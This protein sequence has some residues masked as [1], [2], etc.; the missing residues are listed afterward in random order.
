MILEQLVLV[1][2][3]IYADSNTIELRPPSEDRPII[4]IGGLNGGG[5][6]T[7]LDAIQLGFF[8]RNAT[9]SNRGRLPY[10]DYLRLSINRSADP[11]EGA[12]IEVHFERVVEGKRVRFALVRAWRIANG[13]VQE[14]VS[15]TR[16]ELPDPLLSE[17]WEEYIESYLPSKLA[18]LFFFDGEQIKE[19]ADGDSAA[20][21]LASAVQTL[22]GLD[23]VDR[24]DEDLTTLER[25]KKQ[26][27]LSAADQTRIAELRAIVESASEVAANAHQD[28]AHHQTKTDLLRK[29]LNAL[30]SQF[31]KEGGELFLRREEL[32]AE[33][34]RLDDELVKSADGLRRLSSGVAP[35][36]LIEPLLSQVEQ[37]SE[38]ELEARHEKIISHAEQQRDKQILKD[39]KKVIPTESIALVESVLEKNRPKR[40]HGKTPNLLNPEEEF[41]EE[42]RKLTSLILPQA[43][44]DLDVNLKTANDL[45]ELVARL[46]QQLGSV[47]DADSLAKLQREMTRLEVQVRD[48]EAQQVIH[49][50]RMRQLVSDHRNKDAA[51]KK[52]LDGLVDLQSTVEHDARILQRLPKI[53]DTL[54][55]FRRKVVERH[56]AKLERLILESFQQLLR[57]TDLVR[58][59]RI[60][61]ETFRMELVSS[62]GA[63][64]PFDRLSAGERQ[65]LAT[66]MLWGLAKASGRPLPTIIDTPLGRL[67]SSHRAHLVQRYFPVASHQVI[68]LSTDEEID[69]RYL[70]MM[71][72]FVGRTY[73]L[74][75]DQTSQS[76]RIVDGYLF[77][78]ETTR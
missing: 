77:E 11:A 2:F 68:L 73:R 38:A 37:Q 45:R 66:A 42:L 70:A 39:L 17:H 62:D 51:L 33:K 57:K 75:F 26:S 13:S 48:C 50:E 54:R 41:P 65:L 53:Q 78:H 31:R 61:P 40:D 15:V 64:L 56:A 12:R 10:K 18:H 67:D 74:H 22:L 16:D 9:C 60:D 35:L 49:D 1:N 24:L 6:T 43:R 25:R 20:R 30:Q 46:D 32:E 58:G 29:E 52:A 23:L 3:G 27:T 4:L 36:L 5:K 76:T 34:K 7:L 59:L 71:K 63:T 14:S 19:L 8:G 28:A 44:A 69:A 72:P 21:I 47:P 55:Q